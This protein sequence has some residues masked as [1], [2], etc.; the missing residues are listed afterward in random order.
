MK[1]FPTLALLQR[2]KPQAALCC[3]RLFTWTERSMVELA[4]YYGRFLL[5]SATIVGFRHLS[6]KRKA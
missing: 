1:Y 3:P 2:K 6:S 4:D 5:V